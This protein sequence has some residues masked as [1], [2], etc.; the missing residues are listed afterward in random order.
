MAVPGDSGVTT[1]MAPDGYQSDHVGLV[2]VG[3]QQ[4]MVPRQITVPTA[5]LSRSTSTAS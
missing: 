5:R 2:H 1:V 4:E 3:P